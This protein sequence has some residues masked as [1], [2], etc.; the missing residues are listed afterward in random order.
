MRPDT[1]QSPT[2]ANPL[3]P[4]EFD[5][6]HWPDTIQAVGGI[7]ELSIHRAVVGAS[8]HKAKRIVAASARTLVFHRV[9]Q[10]HALPRKCHL[11]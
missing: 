4:H 6:R 10:C 5:V 1:C 9:S 2:L 8:D 7:R 11:A 3:E